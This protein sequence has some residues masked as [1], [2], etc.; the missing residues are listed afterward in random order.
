M[1]TIFMKHSEEHHDRDAGRDHGRHHHHGHHEGRGHRGGGPGR[2]FESG[3]LRFV[4]LHLM[5]D[6][7]RHGYEI[8]KLIE[9]HVSGAHSPSPGVIYPTLTLLEEMSL[10]ASTADGARKLYTI[11]EAGRRELAANRAATDAIF[12]RMKQTGER[13]ARE[14]SGPIV[15]AVENLKLVLRMRGHEWLPEQM[16]TATDIIDNAA[17]QIERL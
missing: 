4:I 8:I 9:S 1:K 5:S 14:R 15:R 6:A 11:T 3:D 2:F 7:P 17:R 10:A 13:H 12:Q 16:A